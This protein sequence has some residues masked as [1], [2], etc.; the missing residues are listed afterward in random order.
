M[1]RC[2]NRCAQKAA[3]QRRREACAS[4]RKARAEVVRAAHAI[5]D[6]YRRG[7]RLFTM[8]NGGSSCDAAHIA[9]EFQHP[10][11]TGRPALTAINLAHDIAMLTA[12]GNDVGFEHVFVRQV[13]AQARRGDGADRRLDQRQFG[14]PAG[15]VRQGERA[16]RRD[17]RAHRR[18]RRHGWRRAPRIDHCLVVR[19]DSIHR[20][21]ETHVAIY[22]IL[23]DLMHTLLADDRGGLGASATAGAGGHAM[24]YVDEFRDPEKA[25]TLAR[26]DRSAGGAA[27]RARGSGRC[28]SWKCAAATR[29]R[30]SATASSN[31][32]RR[33]SSSC[34]VP[35]A[36]CACCRWGGSTIAS[37][38]RERPDVIFT[39]F[40]DAMRVPG[41][42]KSLLQAK[43]DGADV[44]MVY[45]P[46]D[47]LKLARANPRARGDLLRARLRDHDAEHR[48]DRAAGAS[49]KGSRNFSLFCN[50]ITII[51]TIK[52][53]LDSPDLH[54]RRLSRPGPRQHGDRHPALRLHR[55]S[56]TAS[57][58]SSPGFEPLD[59]LQ[60]LW[61]V[62]QADR[63]KAAARSR[64][65][66]RASCRR[67]ATRRRSRRSAQVFELREFFEWRGLG[68]IDHSGVRMRAPFARVRR[69]AQVRRAEREDRRSAS[70]A[71][72]ARC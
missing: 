60:S 64:T 33:P 30:S 20:V 54:A 49:A 12:V 59:V 3:G 44:R 72:A 36:R 2:S 32:A 57:R 9:V 42:K 68:S 53:I 37:R 58:S 34:T 46:L 45:S 62:L 31:A 5:A 15:R 25:R 29:T 18:R 16:W 67:T 48:A 63:A 50:H 69:R 27:R 22:H 17:H 65:S 1:P 40:G 8:G 11:T 35:A 26:R 41:S 21:Q 14:E 13:I 43:A 71:S 28:R 56:T 47:A 55:A 4:S 7:G 61:M 52:A 24:N 19:S 10:V 6:V 23:W 38:S 39:T 51:P 66:T 70:R